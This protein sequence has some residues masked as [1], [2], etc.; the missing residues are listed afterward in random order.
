MSQWR[1]QRF[2]DC[3]AILV[4]IDFET[5]LCYCFRASICTDAHFEYS[6]FHTRAVELRR[7][8]PTNNLTGKRNL[9]PQVN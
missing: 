8:D 2:D 6:H 9:Q 1:S 7:R 5:G 4:L 3:N